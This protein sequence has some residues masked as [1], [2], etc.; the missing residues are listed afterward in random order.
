MTIIIR[1]FLHIEM[2]RCGSRD[3]HLRYFFRVPMWTNNAKK[4][5]NLSE[6]IPGWAHTPTLQTNCLPVRKEFVNTRM[7]RFD[8]N[9][10]NVCKS[11]TNHNLWVENTTNSKLCQYYFVKQSCAASKG[12]RAA[13]LAKLGLDSKPDCME[14]KCGFGELMVEFIDPGL[15]MKPISSCK[16][17]HTE[18]S[19]VSK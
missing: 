9:N 15:V 12:I 16:A 10:S 4:E 18:V 14:A 6:V 7:F 17:S 1:W 13:R 5:D 19:Q 11:H 3:D 2:Y 8:I